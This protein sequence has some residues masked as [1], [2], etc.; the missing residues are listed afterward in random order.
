MASQNQY[1]ITESD[2]NNLRQW[3]SRYVKSFYSFDPIIQQALVLKE[4]HSLRVC[5]EI[6][7]IGKHLDLNH[8]SLRLAEAMALFHDIG[9]F[10]Q[11]TLYLTFVDK[12]S[13]NHGELGV[14]VLKDKK[15]LAALD[16]DTQEL[17]LKA[18]SYHNR[19][20]VPEDESHICIYFS[21]LLRDA[22]KL[23][24]FNLVSTYYYINHA[25]RSAAVELDL[26]DSPE[27]SAEILDS[28]QEGKM[29]RIQQLRSLNDFKLL[30]M[31][32]IYDINFQPTFQM[33]HERDY[34]K[35]I[36]E[37]LPAS[38]RIDQIYFSLLSHLKRNSKFS[39]PKQL[40]L[41]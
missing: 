35:M 16:E 24:I 18:I 22:D 20:S 21:K 31:A 1:Q 9:R 26:P 13:E 5:D 30:Q 23:D 33:I 29:I 11:Y 2:L 17:I 7:N 25:E 27:V 36:R 38:E 8:N 37:T 10:E 34:L 3:F 28:L 32:W 40:S 39:A 12:K 6:I 14:K 41:I 4:N 15:A 19:L